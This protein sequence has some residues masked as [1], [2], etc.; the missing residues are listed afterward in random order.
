M[1]QYLFAILAL[2]LIC[3]PAFA[4]EA[5]VVY[6]TDE[7][8][9]P[10]PVP[11]LIPYINQGD[12]VYVG[13]T[14]DLSGVLAPY[15]GMAYWDGFDMYDSVPRYNLT[16]PD[17][18]RSYYHFYIDP[19]IFTGRMGYWY[20]YNGKFEKQGNNQ[21]FF[22]MPAK[23]FNSTLTF[24]NGTSLNLSEVVKQNYTQHD[25]KPAPLLP[26]KH[27]SDYV[28]AKGDELVLPEGNYRVWV[29]GRVSGIYANEGHNITK[30]QITALDGGNYD[31]VFQYPGNNTIY[32]AACDAKDCKTLI[33]G[34][35]GQKPVDIYGYQPSVVYDKLKGMLAGTDDTLV[36]YDM[37]V[38]NPYITIHQA[39]EIEYTTHSALNVRGY[40]NVENGTKITVSLD[41]K[42]AYYKDIPNIQ[43]QT[44]AVRTSPGNLSYYSVNVPFDYDDLAA[45]ARN[46]TLTARTELG[47]IV[48]KD[49]KISIMPAD[50][51]RPNATLKYIE[52]R[53]P[54]VPTPTPEIVT[55][56]RTKIVTQ[57]ITIPV[58]P[59]NE[60][61]YEQQRKAQD[62]I[63][64]GWVSLAVTAIVALVVLI[65][66]GWYAM[67]VW[68]RL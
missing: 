42:N 23:T 54:F 41:E 2:G 32:D 66:L 51:Y 45:D 53:N 14:V 38:E 55:I 34:L 43:M 56:E 58:T 9:T 48:Q 22:V 61:V 36:E 27:I 37:Q 59:T 16:M 6:Y 68:R 26:E 13:D 47:G 7:I 65:G 52:G 5:V 11:T 19:N 44:T 10:T 25:I 57:T 40:S 4:S 12:T 49:F 28:V 33:P 50:S 1:R 46:H 20:K 62:D 24:P 30:E 64:N 60:T 35:Y 67:R 39:D 21:L 31:I 8:V 18:K 17:G 63:T 15:P 3:F 29:F